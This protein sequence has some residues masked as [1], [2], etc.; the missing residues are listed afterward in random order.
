MSVYQEITLKVVADQVSPQIYSYTAEE[1]TL[2]LHLGTLVLDSFKDDKIHIDHSEKLQ[3]LTQELETQKSSF[4]FAVEKCKELVS[5]QYKERL[6]Y[7]D[8]YIQELKEQIAEQAKS[9]AEQKHQIM[10]E[11]KKL[12]ET[13]SSGKVQELQ[14]LTQKI[15]QQ[16]TKFQDLYNAHTKQRSMLEIGDEGESIYQELAME[17][18]RFFE[19]FDMVNVASEPNK[20][21]FHMF[22]KDFSVLVDV[23]NWDNNIEGK[24][25]DKLQRDLLGN[26]MMF[27]WMVS[28]KTNIR[29]FDNFPIS[30]EWIRHDKCII[31]VNSLMKQSDPVEFLR[32]AYN[33][34]SIMYNVNAKYMANQE[35]K[36]EELSNIYANIKQLETIVLEETSV[37][38]GMIKSMELMNKNIADMSSG[39]ERLKDSNKLVKEI[40]R[41]KLNDKSNQLLTNMSV[42]KF[43]KKPRGR[44]AAATVGNE[45]VEMA[46]DA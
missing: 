24:E 5:D 42:K 30:V 37:I 16:V 19:K 43:N 1:I 44:K 3:S 17:S 15:D 18:F 10:A 34:C 35:V 14:A 41:D 33:F 46:E 21:D 22:F 13:E 9:I 29:K 36:N 45:V 39:M 25:R 26:D 32:L 8:K 4:N 12:Y 7:K 31:Y 23:K 2:I 20:G 28:L 11:S 27:G 38:S 6:E 40:I